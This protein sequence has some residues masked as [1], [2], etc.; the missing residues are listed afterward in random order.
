M[1][2][3]TNEDDFLSETKHILCTSTLAPMARTKGPRKWCPILGECTKEGFASQ[4]SRDETTGGIS[5]AGKR[6]CLSI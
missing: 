3:N 5:E 4:P 2:S 1:T 6:T